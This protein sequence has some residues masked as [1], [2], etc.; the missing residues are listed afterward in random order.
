MN[1]LTTDQRGDLRQVGLLVNQALQLLQR[2]E[3]E[4]VSDQKVPLMNSLHQAK[5]RVEAWMIDEGASADEMRAM[6]VS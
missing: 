6:E 3:Y 2:R 5:M 1:G 4:M